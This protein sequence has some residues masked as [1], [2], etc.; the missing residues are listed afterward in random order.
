MRPKV[1]TFTTQLT[2]KCLLLEMVLEREFLSKGTSGSKVLLEEVREP[3]GDVP[4]SQEEHTLDLRR[5][6]EP[7]H[8]EPEVRRSERSRHEPDRFGDWVTDDHALFIIESDEPTSYEEALIGPDSDKWLEAAKSEM[9]S[10]SQNNVW[11]LVALPD[12]VKAI[13]CKWIFK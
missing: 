1:I 4:T 2:R 10:M 3:H 8:V 12:G 11:T 6:V 7:I 13:E 5:V 9:E